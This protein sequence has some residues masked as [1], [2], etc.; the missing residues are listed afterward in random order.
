MAI[1]NA[2]ERRRG[3][4]RA[5]MDEVQGAI[6]VEGLNRRALSRI[7]SALDAVA[8][9]PGLF[10]EADYPASTDPGGIALYQIHVEP[11]DGLALYLNVLQPGKSSKPHNHTTWAVIA[12]LKGQE[13]NRVYARKDD[14]S[15]AGRAELEV[16]RSVVVQPGTTVSFM[17]DDIHSIHGQGNDVIRHLHLYGRPL[18]RLDGRLGFD[19]DAGTVVNY[20]ANYMTPTIIRPDSEA[21]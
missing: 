11:D 8:G 16:V 18:E 10:D 21:R 5:L 1:E 13:T 6:A 20:N 15:V 12:A 3:A 14:G 2:V 9:T 7:E 4:V 17:P 19:L